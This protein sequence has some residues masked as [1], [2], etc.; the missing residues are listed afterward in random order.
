MSARSNPFQIVRDF[1]FEVERFT[2]APHVI[3]VDSCTNALG[4]C[5]EH[6]M[7]V[8]NNKHNISMGVTAHMPKYT[9]IGVPMQ[10]KRAGL[11][12]DFIDDIWEGAYDIGFTYYNEDNI[13]C[14]FD[15][16][17]FDSARRF[18]KDMWNEFE[19]SKKEHK[20]ICV[21]F[22]KT[23]ILGHTHGGAILTN[24]GEFAHWAKMMR[25]DGRRERTSAKDDN[26]TVLGRHCYM[27]P[28][29]AAA[30]THKLAYLPDYPSDLKN[31]DYPD[32]SKLE[33]F[34]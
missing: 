10:A 28:E 20:Y 25:F 34:K 11:E 15:G 16:A 24:N 13:V 31:D 12:L 4:I 14:E 18:R 22:H 17:V 32:L 30:L 19:V 3:A 8:L 7:Q 5:F 33:I 6:V 2:G 9:Y 1:E 23:K 26:P 29:V 27:M 21:S